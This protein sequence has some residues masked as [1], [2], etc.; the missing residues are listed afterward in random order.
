MGWLRRGGREQ[1]DEAARDP[2]LPA[3]GAEAGRRFRAAAM[4]AFRS[5]G[6]ETTY[7]AGELHALGDARY[8]LH[9]VSVQA[10]GTPERQWPQLLARHAAILIAAQ[11]AAPPEEAQL[12][13]RLYLSLWHRPDVPWVPDHALDVAD[14]LIALPALDLPDTVQTAGAAD[15]VAQW[16]GWARVRELGLA[17]LARERADEVLTVGGPRSPAEA[18]QVVV[19]GYF[20]AS[21]LLVMDR[22]LAQDL[23]VERPAHGAVVA[24]PN[25]QLLAVHVLRGLD[26]VGAVPG[27]LAFAA[28]EVGRPGAIS[29]HLYYWRD[30]HVQ[31]ITRIG[32]DGT[33]VVEVTGEF[34]RALGELSD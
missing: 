5:H 14:D 24:V 18:V 4:A 9:N 20:T 33:A 31:R 7:A 1:P 26:V 28:G 25:R 29:R 21:R 32:T 6:V 12:H 22:V 34:A 19:G 23:G 17:N 3:L 30:G 15:Q 27:L 11:R 8:P 16:G 10:A 13:R 2:D